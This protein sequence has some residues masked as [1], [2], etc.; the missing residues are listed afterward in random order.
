MMRW[1]TIIRARG[2]L[3][4]AVVLNAVSAGATEDALAAVEA[5]IAAPFSVDETST[6]DLATALASADSASYLLFDVREPAEFERSHVRG[7]LRVA[8]DTKASAFETEFSN[9]VKDKHLIFY[10]SVGYRS[11]VMADRVRDSAKEA[12]ALSVANLRGGVFRWYNEGR[13][14]HDAND[15]TD[16]IHPYDRVWGV[17]VNERRT[18]VV[19]SSEK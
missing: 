19:K 15:T 6:K 18:G 8:P 16:A 2:A 1:L 14:V 4:C 3:V 13:V 12:G 5:A 17:F 11:S 10:C 9:K 7:A